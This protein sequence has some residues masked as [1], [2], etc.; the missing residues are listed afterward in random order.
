MGWTLKRNAETSVQQDIE[1]IRQWLE[2]PVNAKECGAIGNGSHDDTQAIQWMFNNHLFCEFTPGNYV[3]KETIT[4]PDRRRIIGHHRAKINGD[5]AHGASMTDAKGNWFKILGGNVSIENMHYDGILMQPDALDPSHRYVLFFDGTFA[6]QFPNVKIE[7]CTFEN[8]VYSGDG[9]ANAVEHAL[10]VNGIRNIRIINCDFLD[11][12]GAAMLVQDSNGVRVTDCYLDDLGYYN[13]HFYDGVQDVT[14]SRNHWGPN[15]KSNFGGLIDCMGYD[16]NQ[17]CENFEISDN[18]LQGEATYNY[19]IRMES[20]RK[21]TI[22]RNMIKTVGNGSL[23]HVLARTVGGVVNR[24]PQDITI[25]KNILIANTTS[26]TLRAI[27]LQNDRTDED[28]KNINVNGNIAN[29]GTI[30]GTPGGAASHF[31]A[32]LSSGERDQHGKIINVDIANNIASFSGNF[33]GTPARPI[34]GITFLGTVTGRTQNVNIHHNILKGAIGGPSASQIAIAIR[35]S[36]D[37]VKISDNTIDNVYWAIENKGYA[38][39]EFNSGSVEPSVG[40]ILT[41]AISGATGVFVGTFSPLTSGTWAGGDAVGTLYVETV[42]GTFQAENI[43]NTTTATANIATITAY[44]APASQIEQH[45]NTVTNVSTA[46]GIDTLPPNNFAANDATPS[47]EDWVSEWRTANDNTAQLLVTRLDG[48][49]PGRTYT[50]LNNDGANRTVLVDDGDN[51]RLRGNWT[52]TP[53][54]KIVL[55]CTGG[56][57]TQGYG[58]LQELYRSSDSIVFPDADR[59]P[60]TYLHVKRDYISV[61]DLDLTNDWVQTNEQGVNTVKLIDDADLPTYDPRGGALALITAPLDNDCVSLQFAGASGSGEMVQLVAGKQLYVRYRVKMSEITQIAAFVGLSV[62]D[63]T[64][65]PADDAYIPNS[66]DNIGFHK[67]DAATTWGFQCAKDKIDDTTTGVTRRSGVANTSTDWMWMAFYYDG[68]SSVQSYIDGVA[69]G[70]AILSNVP[71][72]EPLCLTYLL[73]NGD[74]NS[75]T[76]LVDFDEIIQER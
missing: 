63:T 22:A 19:G 13:I 59:H 66:S 51:L 37:H 62:R 32:F 4:I 70:T 36:V 74:G 30:D 56:R 34:S 45:N 58:K 11:A 76:M 49:V 73:K 28:M 8:L 67:A 42:T 6:T 3:I 40:D 47:L 33:A 16:T 64:L 54:D 50:I 7:A 75:R 43:D 48:G 27:Q 41:G 18:I 55:L 29:S 71:N 65:S 35:H 14:V 17:I 68:I 9:S 38:V 52:G 60:E 72:D 5:L 25:D 57:N 39:I 20:I 15:T 24:A 44:G 69:A 53:G 10:R 61:A 31:G 2:S 12:T 26:T 21:L 23:I 46:G 1:A